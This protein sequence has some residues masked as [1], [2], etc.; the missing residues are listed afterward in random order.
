MP[1]NR[2]LSICIAVSV[3]LHVALTV[4]LLLLPE[5]KAPPSDVVPVEL[6]DIPRAT[7]FL[8][9]A[10]GIVQGGP[11][12]SRPSPA[13]PPPAPPSTRQAPPPQA[14]ASPAGPARSPEPDSPSP[15][16]ETQAPQN[17]AQEKPSPGAATE[18]PSPAAREPVPTKLPPGNSATPPPAPPPKPLKDLLPKLGAI[19][20]SQSE[21][22]GRRSNPGNGSAVGT[23]GKPKEKGQ[24]TE[25]SGGGIHLSSISSP[26]FQ[27]QTWYDSVRRKIELVWVYPLEAAQAGIQGEVTIDFVI[28]RNGSVSSVRL[29]KSSGYKV[30]DDEAIRAIQ[31][32]GRAR[33]NPIPKSYNIPSL[34]IRGRFM[35]IQGGDRSFR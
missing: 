25:E 22:G 9:P 35:Y 16:P 15:S 18:K 6:A 8:E 23:E 32:V 34:S 26:E 2:L 17:Q 13:P 5:W 28:E 10:P 7:D 20:R 29:I 11:Q 12:P 31:V 33:F 14:K 3:A 24:I 27:H 21:P 19:V 30:L 4:V 1:R